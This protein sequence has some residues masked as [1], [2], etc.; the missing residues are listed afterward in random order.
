MINR[1]SGAV[2]LKSNASG[3]RPP[4]RSGP[5]SSRSGSRGPGQVRIIAG[6]Y[7]RTPIPV[8]DAPGLRPTP[9]RIRETLFNWLNHWIPDWSSTRVLDL[10]AGSGALGFEC[11]SRGAAEVVLVEHHA[12]AAQALQRLKLRLDCASLNIVA[13][14]WRAAIGQLPQGHF[15]LAFLDPPYDSGLLPVALRAVPGLLKPGALVYAESAAPLETAILDAAGFELLRQAHA[16][17]V[18]S[19]LLRPQSC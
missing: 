9:D 19:H 6:R 2:S 3:S 17:A 18:W 14:D 1:N 8:V 15:D 5:A 12:A 11:A 10:F 4:S 7:R 13:R 16:G